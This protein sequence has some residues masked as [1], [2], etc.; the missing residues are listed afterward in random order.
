MSKKKVII[1]L[2]G[3]GTVG[4][5]VIKLLEE[6]ARE[7]KSRHGLIFYIKRIAEKDPKRR[8]AL[9]QSGHILCKNVNEILDDPE[10]DTV[11]EVISGIGDAKEIIKGSLKKRK[12][13]VTGNKR[14]LALSGEGLFKLASQ[15][16]CHL[17]FRAALTGCQV[18]QSHLEYGVTIKSILG[19]FNGTTNYILSEM[20]DNNMSFADAL[21][22]AQRL[23]YAEKDPSL[24][25]DGRDTANKV[26]LTARLAFA[27]R[28]KREDFYCEGIRDIR[29]QDVEFAKQQGY[30]I[31]LLGII[32]EE[33][34]ILEVRVH[35]CLV[36]KDTLLASVKGVH[37]GIRVISDAGEVNNWTAEGAGGRAAAGAI[38]YDLID[39]ANETKLRLP[40][41]VRKPSIKKMPS[42]KC[43]Y[44][45]RVRV[46]NK[47]AVL[48]KIASALAK[49]NINIRSVVQKGVDIGAIVPI[50]IITDE[51]MEKEVQKAAKTIN[52]LPIVK[53]RMKLIRIEECVS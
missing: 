20:E 50:V 2:I 47:P 11:I 51:A 7:L 28:L 35:P 32:R 53:S 6:T 42:L 12:N 39:I 31:K 18:I 3:A 16:D 33:N 41:L 37:N 21:K 22:E 49:H 14:L 44:Y 52:S 48:A 25:I 43:K 4:N 8:K 46:M 23:G 24:D 38:I 30:A 10:I 45:I 13:V 34:N 1:G 9:K 29:I 17:G 36:P 40:E 19:I 27:H 26:I 5:G 15:Y